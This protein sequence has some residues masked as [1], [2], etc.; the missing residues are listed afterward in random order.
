MIQDSDMGEIIKEIFSKDEIS[1]QEVEQATT[2]LGR[3]Y[4][5]LQAYESIKDIK[6]IL[7]KDDVS[8]LLTRIDC[9]TY[10]FF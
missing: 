9:L 4:T 8:F 3:L 1:E 5:L 7:G 6:I 10:V 2:E